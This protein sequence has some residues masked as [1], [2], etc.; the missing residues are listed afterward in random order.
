MA[1]V[2]FVVVYVIYTYFNY[3]QSEQF[4]RF[5]PEIAKSLRRAL[6]YSNYA[7]D[8]KLALKWYKIALEQCEQHGL[9]PFSNEVMGVKI[10]LAAWLEKLG[11]VEN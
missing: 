8:P 11:P 2:S 3:F 5:P 9:D 10:Q 4:T 6:Y 7:P 1:G